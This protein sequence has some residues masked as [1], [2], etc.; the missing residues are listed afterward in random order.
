MDE[1]RKLLDSLMGNHRNVDRA[2]AKA[3]KGQNFKEENV[4]KWFLVGFCPKHED[5]FHST[6]RDIGSC[7]KVHSDAL[8]AEY[9]A[10][11]DKKRFQAEYERSLATYL[12]E[13]VRA[14]DDWV[15]R[16]R[17]AVQ[18][19]NQAILDSGPNEVAAAEIKSLKEKASALLAEAESLAEE[20][21][22]H[23]SRARIEAAEE[24]KQKAAD[25]EE[26]AK[27]T[28]EEDVCTLC[29]SRMES[30]DPTYARFRH[31]EGKIHVGYMKI[32]Q[33]LA[34]LKERQKEF[35]ADPDLKKKD[36]DR[37]SRGTRDRR[38][39]RSRD[40]R[41]SRSR[42]RRRSRSRGRGG[43]T[44]EAP[45]PQEG[46]EGKRPDEG[47][48]PRERPR[49]RD[50]EEEKFR[51]RH[52]DAEEKD[53]G[54]AAAGDKN[55][56]NDGRHRDRRSRRDVRGD[57]DPLGV[58]DGGSGRDRPRGRDGD[59]RGDRERGR[60]D[61]YGG[62]RS[63]RDRGRHGRERDDGDSGRGGRDDMNGDR[64][65]DRDRGRAGYR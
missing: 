47:A 12:Q 29:G 32:R 24:F 18:A 15:A 5:I 53:L 50:D 46:V 11:P 42:D 60:G 20:G 22:I 64:G 37:E 65:R 61:D 16:E 31:Q 35:E 9:E 39:S 2:E 23:E 7:K 19:A 59:R 30:G 10:H 4:C 55:T 28:R 17:R 41:R 45:A 36:G 43:G 6:K 62:D 34:D 52:R 8:R 56:D 38:G 33:W 63:G 21:N 44:G 1:A 49:D 40:R 57:A 25:W 54:G 3:K 48:K 13:L 26:K 51:R 14:A 58:Y 27:M